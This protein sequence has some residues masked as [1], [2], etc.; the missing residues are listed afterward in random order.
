M[1]GISIQNSLPEVVETSS[2]ALRPIGSGVMLQAF[3][4]DVPLDWYGEVNSKISE[5]AAAGFDNIWLP[6]PSKTMNGRYSM[7]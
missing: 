7:G 1:A 4:W 5:I 3:Y 6:P 2:A